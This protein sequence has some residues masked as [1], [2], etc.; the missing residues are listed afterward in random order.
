MSSCPVCGG[1]EAPYFVKRLLGKYDVTYYFCDGCRFLHTEQPYWLEESYSDAIAM[2]DTGII[3]RNVVASATAGALFHW[4]FRGS[5]K[6]L[7]VAGGYGLLTRL[8]RDFGFDC[9]WN[10]PFTKNMFA[11]G[12]EAPFPAHEAYRGVTA[13][14]AIEHVENPL[15]FCREVLDSTGCEA[16]VF[17]TEIYPGD[18]PPDS[19]WYYGLSAGQHISFC[20]TDTLKLIARTLNVCLH[21]HGSIHML[22]R[23]KINDIAFRVLTGR[24][25]TRLFPVIARLSMDPLI[26]IDHLTLAVQVQQSDHRRS[27]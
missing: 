3:R 7:D 1:R 8:M 16:F 12:F 20:H 27:P 15:K 11:R 19:W 24:I 25:Y 9:Y 22:T 4:M 10:D 18:R 26:N 6:Y 13:F 17:S 21:S 2:A 14:E 23:K 5:G